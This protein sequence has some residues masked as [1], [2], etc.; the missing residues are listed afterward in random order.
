MSSRAMQTL[1]GELLERAR[2]AVG[3]LSNFHPDCPFKIGWAASYEDVFSGRLGT[4]HDAR[5]ILEMRLSNRR[6]VLTGRG[7]GG[8]TV[9][10]TRLARM[11]LHMRVLPVIIDLVNWTAQD[12]E[13]WEAY[14]TK[15]E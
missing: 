7:G 14:R 1:Y 3:K 6:I 5:A 15:D 10:L 11:S 2:V 13:A 4:P 12:N 9:V 8:K